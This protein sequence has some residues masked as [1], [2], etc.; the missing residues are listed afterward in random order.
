MNIQ[1]T[2]TWWLSLSTQQGKPVVM[3][4][5]GELTEPKQKQR[6]MGEYTRPDIPNRKFEPVFIFKK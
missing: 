5:D 4:L 1:Y 6:Y 2:D 3:N